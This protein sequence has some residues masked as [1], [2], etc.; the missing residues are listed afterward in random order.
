MWE[1]PAFLRCFPSVWPR[2]RRWRPRGHLELPSGATVSSWR[3]RCRRS[4]PS[5]SGCARCAMSSLWPRNALPRPATPRRWQ[6]QRLVAWMMAASLAHGTWRCSAGASSTRCSSRHCCNTP[7]T[8]SSSWIHSTMLAWAARPLRTCGG[9][10]PSSACRRRARQS[11]MSCLSGFTR[12]RCKRRMPIRSCG[13][14]KHECWNRTAS[15]AM[16]SSATTSSP[17]SSAQC[18]RREGRALLRRQRLE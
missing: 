5:C 17:G 9:A 12:W 7:R 3:A 16:R 6:E 14:F 4:R 18:V 15:S 1:V 8:W 10:S 13:D 11:S 2:R